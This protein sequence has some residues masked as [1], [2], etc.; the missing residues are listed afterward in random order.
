MTR[1]GTTTP[2][3]VKLLVIPTV[4]AQRQRARLITSRSYDRNIPTVKNLI[5]IQNV[6][7]AFVLY[8]TSPR[9]SDICCRKDNRVLHI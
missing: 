3:K 5:I 2:P 1:K 9:Y 6:T 4:V 8:C 7:N